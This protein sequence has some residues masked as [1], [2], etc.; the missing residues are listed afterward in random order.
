MKN[1]PSTRQHHKPKTTPVAKK[2]SPLWMVVVVIVV[3]AIGGVT[4][5]L[6]TAD[7]STTN[8]S[9]TTTPANTT[10]K[11]DQDL[12]VGRWTRTDSDGAYAIEI[13][14][15]SADGKLEAS[16][17]NPGP[18]KVGHAEWQKKNNGLTVVVE[19]RDV[20]Y[21]GS[22]YTLNFIPS[23]NRMMG[24][25]YQAVEGTNFDVEFVRSK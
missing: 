22:T 7:K 15:A 17:F 8:S 2:K 9:S 10:V 3:A 1:K 13:K 20:N 14:S 21:P 19:L 11:A 4:W 12:L 23:E 18:I 25:Y 6:Y 5:R 24:N 16:Y